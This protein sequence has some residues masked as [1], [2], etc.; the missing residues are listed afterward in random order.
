MT[1]SERRQL[2][3]RFRSSGMGGSIMDVY[4]AYDQG[5][6]I[7]ADYLQEQGRDQPA[8]LTTPEEQEEGLRPYHAAGDLQKSAVFKD[9]PPNTPFN[10]NGMKVPINIDK[11]NQEGHLVE[12]HKSIP[13]GVRN[14]PTGPYKGDVIETPAKGYQKGGFVNKKKKARSLRE[15]K[16]VV[17]N[18]D[19]RESTHLMVSDVIDN[20]TGEYH[21]WPSIYADSKNNYSDQTEDQAKERGE[22]FTFKNKKRAD[23]FAYGSWKKGK[24]KREAMKDYR[25]IKKQTGGI[26]SSTGASADNPTMDGFDSVEER[27]EWRRSKLQLMQN[28][29]AAGLDVHNRSRIFDDDYR[30]TPPPQDEI[31]NW[32]ALPSAYPTWQRIHHIIPK[33][34]KSKLNSIKQDSIDKKLQTSTSI[35]TSGRAP[36]LV[37]KVNGRMRTGQEPNYYK[38]WDKKS[39]SWK[40]RPVESEEL[41]YYRGK[42][43]IQEKQIIKA[44]F[45][46]GGKLLPKF[47][48][49]RR[50]KI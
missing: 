42:N 7:V 21:V 29:R 6:D 36:E 48:T 47:G 3:D 33:K 11:Y 15:G 19:G 37:Y 17:Q 32:V 20:P 50:K 35:P 27:N 22:Y 25:T 39:K 9:V 45:K 43:K 5:Q 14:I 46:T 24:D 4:K 1:N 49:P 18:D 34:L 8:T 13:P 23:K 30:Y 26:V 10:T 44:S 38:V 12:S 41:E 28:R 40:V 16:G 31:D 2:L